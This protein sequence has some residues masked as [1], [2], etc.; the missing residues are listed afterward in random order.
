MRTGT[1]I[2][3]D[4][5]AKEP[6]GQLSGGGFQ[7]G[8]DGLKPTS[9]ACYNQ[10]TKFPE[11]TLEGIFDL[12][13]RGFN[14]MGVYV[15]FLGM[16]FYW[17]WVTTTF[18]SG[19]L[20]PDIVGVDVLV[21]TFWLWST[22]SHS[23]VLALLVMVANRIG[24]LIES[25]VLR[26]VSSCGMILGTMALSVTAALSASESSEFQMVVPLVSMVIGASTS[27]HVLLW[28]NLYAK[29]P[30]T[31]VAIASLVSMC[32]GLLLYFAITLCPPLIGMVTVFLLP[33]FSSA[34]MSSSLQVVKNRSAGS[35]QTHP[36][37]RVLDS[38]VLVI[39]LFVFAL[40]GEML[41]V[42]SIELTDAS[43]TDMGVLY[44]L[45]GVIGLLTLI[46]YFIFPLGALQKKRITLALVRTILIIMAAA[47]LV[48]PFLSGYS[49]AICYGIFGAGFWCFRAISWIFCFLLI[50]RFSCNPLRV[51]GILDGSFALSV[52]VSAQVNSWLVESIRVGGTEV[53][54]VSLITVFVLMVIAM[55]VL[56]GKQT[57]T[58]L[59]GYGDETTEGRG[60]KVK[61]KD[62]AIAVC[63]DSIAREFGLSPR[64]TEVVELLAKGRSLPFIQN[65]L[66]I[67]A[68][69]AQ[70]HARH[71]YKK[72]SVHSRQEFLDVIER[73]MHES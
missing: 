5:A 13:T 69:T 42:F 68:G 52:V 27:W 54:T 71:I 49:F 21:E 22:W 51:V 40:C 70:T 47:F 15:P 16:G 57:A 62:D 19:V 26:R 36:A 30:V 65:E 67:S 24:S 17:A 4:P 31:H 72:M 59:A 56:N 46:G 37:I 29:M 3:N 48:A 33:I 23:L 7:D 14:N 10:K 32:V 61:G 34:T 12:M 50:E 6:G 35:K 28:G 64:E 39:A 58:V 66:Y 9:R 60:G 43:V 20:F 38:M 41:R 53:T 1:G 8:S 2:S 18:Y 63:M 11:N 55:F 25:T 44:L 45:G 73:R